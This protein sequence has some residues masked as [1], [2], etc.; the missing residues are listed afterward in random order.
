MQTARLDLLAK[1]GSDGGWSDLDSMESSVYTPAVALHSVGM[2]SS[3]PVNQRGIQSMPKT[4]NEN[5]S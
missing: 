2:P 5:G 1:P 4:K 3:D